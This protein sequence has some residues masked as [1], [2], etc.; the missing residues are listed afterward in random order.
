MLFNIFTGFFCVLNSPWDVLLP[1]IVAVVGVAVGAIAMPLIYNIVKKRKLND[2]NEQANAII[3]DA[4]TKSKN[5]HKET[6]LASKEEILKLKTE[7]DKEVKD[8]RA[9]IQR[10]EQRVSQREDN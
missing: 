9:E 3:Q 6:V 2:A 7:F 1:I 10:S 4:I 5:L 8:R